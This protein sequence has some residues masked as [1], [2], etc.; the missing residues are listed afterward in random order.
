MPFR[1]QGNAPHV[2]IEENFLDDQSGAWNVQRSMIRDVCAYMGAS[3]L[4]GLWFILA[5]TTLN[6]SAQGVKVVET[7]RLENEDGLTPIGLEEI[8]I[9]GLAGIGLK[10]HF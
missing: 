4:S 1:V 6:V 5:V 9:L 3:P 7:L 10:L 2:D 8:A